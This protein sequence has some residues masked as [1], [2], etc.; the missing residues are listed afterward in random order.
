[1]KELVKE[2]LERE[3]ENQDKV[4]FWSLKEKRGSKGVRVVSTVKCCRKVEEAEG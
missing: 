1:M 4:V 2:Q 3:N